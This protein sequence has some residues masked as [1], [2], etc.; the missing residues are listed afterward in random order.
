MIN[1][2]AELFDGNEM[3]NQ[4]VCYFWQHM[5]WDFGT[6]LSIAVAE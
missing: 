1:L 3:R 2:N 6:F 5:N 4:V